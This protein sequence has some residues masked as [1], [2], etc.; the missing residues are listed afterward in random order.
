MYANC[1]L[2]IKSFLAIVAFLSIPAC[3]RIANN[4]ELKYDLAS[5]ACSFG[6]HVYALQ[7]VRDRSKGEVVMAAATVGDEFSDVKG[8][9][10]GDSVK[11]G[12]SYHING[13]S[14]LEEE[15]RLI[16]SFGGISKIDINRSTTIGEMKSIVESVIK[17]KKEKEAAQ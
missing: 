14:V 7:V 17:E 13:K 2:R 11:P 12:F 10:E 8:I 15:G 6:D 3:V 1:L 16:I 5:T 9:I 4:E